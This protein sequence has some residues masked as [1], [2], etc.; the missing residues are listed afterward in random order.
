MDSEGTDSGVA[1]TWERMG[2]DQIL[3]KSTRFTVRPEFDNSCFL[4][5]ICATR[6]GRWLRI[7]VLCV[8]VNDF[9]LQLLHLGSVAP[10]NANKLGASPRA[11]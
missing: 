1:V 2:F 7:F 6:R 5:R 3:V 10:I 11:A 8:F 9:S 4:I